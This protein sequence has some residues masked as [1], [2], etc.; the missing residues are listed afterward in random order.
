M[1]KMD[2][3]AIKTVHIVCI[4]ASKVCVVKAINSEIYIREPKKRRALSKMVKISKWK[5][6]DNLF[7]DYVRFSIMANS[8]LDSTTEVPSGTQSERAMRWSLCVQQLMKVHREIC[9]ILNIPYTEN[10]DDEFY[11]QFHKEVEK[12]IR[13]KG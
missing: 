2:I 3:Y 5:V 12:Q 1:M 10:R 4:K 8:Y 11:S 13:L 9:T 6:P 7:N